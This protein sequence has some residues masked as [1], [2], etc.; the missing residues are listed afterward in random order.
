MRPLT[1]EKTSCKIQRERGE[2]MDGGLTIVELGG[3]LEVVPDPSSG[4][5][6]RAVKKPAGFSS[7]GHGRQAIT[8]SGFPPLFLMPIERAA[9]SLRMSGCTFVG[10]LWKV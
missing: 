4:S 7:S 5:P 3:K 10:P 6:S 8:V 9:I 2:P 1:L